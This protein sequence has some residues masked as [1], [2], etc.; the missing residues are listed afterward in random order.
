MNES[1]P[2]TLR[3]LIDLLAKLPGIGLKTAERLAF[4]LIKLDKEF[5]SDLSGSINDLKDSIKLAPLCHCLTDTS[6]CQMCDS[7]MRKKNVVCVV[8]SQQDVFYIEKSGYRG[9][10][11]V[12]GGLI[13]P[14]DGI[15][16]EDLN[17]ENLSKRLSGVDEVILA[18]PFSVEGEATSYFLVDFLKDFNVKIS[19]PAKG[20][21]VGVSI[22]YVDQLTLQNSIEERIEIDE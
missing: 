19:R 1:Y 18:I 8:E 11:H 10:Y 13:S 17:I 22:E 15:G 5:S 3:R 16:V 12:L 4:N 9:S 21:P 7:P 20:L 2:K 14:L 6:F